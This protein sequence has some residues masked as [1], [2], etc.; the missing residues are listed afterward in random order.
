MQH[1]TEAR[2][3][4]LF[5]DRLGGLIHEA[6]NQGDTVRVNKLRHLGYQFQLHS[7]Q[8]SAL[9]WAVITNQLAVVQSLCEQDPDALAVPDSLGRTPLYTAIEANHL[10]LAQFL[11]E[12]NPSV[13][14]VVDN[15][16]WT[17]LHRATK[18]SNLPMILF[19]VQQ[20]PDALLVRNALGQLPLHVAAEYARWDVVQVL[21][22]QSPNAIEVRDAKGRTPLHCAVL[23][24]RLDVMQYLYH[25]YP[26]AIRLT[27]H[28]GWTPLHLAA[29]AMRD[30]P[31]LKF[32]VE[33][34]PEGL[35]VKNEDGQL[36]LHVVVNA[37]E[38][39]QEN[40]RYLCQSDPKALRVKDN[41]GLTPFLLAATAYQLPIM[42]IF[43]ELDQAVMQDRDDSGTNP[44]CVF[45][46]TVS[47]IPEVICVADLQWFFQ[48]DEGLFHE[49]NQ[50]GSTLLHFAVLVGNLELAQMVYRANPAALSS[51]NADRC[52][53]MHAASGYLDVSNIN[54]SVVT[55]LHQQE[56]GAELLFTKDHKSRL[57]VH[58]A[59]QRGAL[60]VVKYFVQCEPSVINAVDIEGCAPLHLAAQAG[61]VEMVQFLSGCDRSVVTLENEAGKCA[62]DF[63]AEQDH[64]AVVAF[65]AVLEAALL[66]EQMS[67]PLAQRRSVAHAKKM[68]RW[69]RWAYDMD[70]LVFCREVSRFLRQYGADPGPGSHF[71][72]FLTCVLRMLN[73]N[74]VPQ[75]TQVCGHIAQD[76]LSLYHQNQDEDMLCRAAIF[77]SFFPNDEMKEFQHRIFSLL[78]DTPNAPL[79]ELDPVAVLKKNRVFE[80]YDGARKDGFCFDL[81]TVFCRISGALPGAINSATAADA[82]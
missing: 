15:E 77:F 14:E 2:S 74:K 27:D 37:D 53:P 43:Y 62:I 34:Y 79:G 63:A 35:N 49:V 56:G 19:L 31:V 16:G 47:S 17:V 25:Q 21:H 40:V 59:A 20:Y 50:R 58:Y 66:E 4:T 46:K 3:L 64:K 76:M 22:Q 61:H 12:Q 44:L 23:D 10:E 32:L 71:L 48:C 29:D 60:A 30:L 9:H 13:I 67:F 81:P 57:P 18:Q 45:L 42:R 68:V 69:L 65:L 72:G 41:A 54:L 6:T 70:V 33:V 52:T 26:D 82:G 24:G 75:C 80:V 5:T 38:Y 11:F 8:L 78:L 7:R 1:P 73:P 51:Q 28:Q 36:P 39:V 55:F